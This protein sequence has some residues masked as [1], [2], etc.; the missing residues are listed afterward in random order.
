MPP[1][2]RTDSIRY[3]SARTSP[4][5]GI[6]GR[7]A[8][9]RPGTP[10]GG[11]A[12]M[13]RF[14]LRPYADCRRTYRRPNVTANERPSPPVLETFART[15]LE[16]VTSVVLVWTNPAASS[17]PLMP[18]IVVDTSE[19]VTVPKSGSDVMVHLFG[20]PTVGASTIHSAVVGSRIPLT[21]V[22]V[23]VAPVV[24]FSTV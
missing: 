20:Q 14:R 2:P 17:G 3:R 12:T 9:E 23:N 4:T 18:S 7:L 16:L 6:G 15:S 11:R 1:A 22:T 24:R 19:R 21:D 13:R 10:G 5:I 8:H